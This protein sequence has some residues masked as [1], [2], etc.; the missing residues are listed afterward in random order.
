[1]TPKTPF[2]GT[3]KRHVTTFAK[4]LLGGGA[5]RVAVNLLAGLPRDRFTQDLVLVERRG[6]F[7]AEVRGDVDVT[8]LQRSGRVEG[9]VVPLAR[10]LRRTRPAVLLAHLAHAN[11]AAVT[12][13]RLAGVGTRVVLVEHN[14]NSALDAGRTRSAASRLMQA[15]KSQA[16]RRADLVVG[17]SG[18]VTAYVERTFGVPEAK[19]RTIYNPVVSEALLARSLEPLPH[20]WFVPGGPPVI[21]AAGRLREQKDFSTLLRA[22]ARVRRARPCRLVILGEGELRPALEA[23]VV[24]LGLQD[25]VSLPGFTDNPYAYMR[26]AALFVL[27]SRWEGLPTVLVEALA[28]GTPVVATDCKS[29]PREI[30]GGGR[31]GRLAPVGS[32]GGLADA[33]LAALADPTPRGALE[34]RAANFSYERAITNYAELF[35]SL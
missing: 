11:V 3:A 9:A 28:C 33:V 17:V 4:N 30:L 7:V 31:W 5:E 29:G 13:A 27:S 6:P 12:A 15:V 8:D 23:E 25:A 19:L 14:D 26:A 10:H 24:R 16:Y 1:M 22:F 20:P 35:A 18:G 32:P 2:A 34:W 21:L